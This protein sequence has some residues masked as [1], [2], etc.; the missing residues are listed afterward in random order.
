MSAFGRDSVA[1]LEISDGQYFLRK[2]TSPRIETILHFYVIQGLIQREIDLKA[3]G[4]TLAQ[5]NCPFHSPSN[6][7][8]A[9]A[10]WGKA[11]TNNNNESPLITVKG[12]HK[13]T[14]IFLV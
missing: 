9:D 10:F 12:R 5:F 7:P 11:I 4:S 14:T 2:S 13:I 1:K 3:K 8:A 6:F